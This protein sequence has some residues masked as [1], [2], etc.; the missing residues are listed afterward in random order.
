VA[1]ALLAGLLGGGVGAAGVALV[2]SD[3]SSSMQEP[4]PVDAAPLAADNTSVVAVADSLLPSV[5]QIKVSSET[6]Q[7][8]GSGFVLDDSGHVSPTTTSW[9]WRPTVA[10][11]RSCSTAARNAEPPSS[12]AR[13]RTTWR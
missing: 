3:E 2:D 13:R 11:S 5:V 1:T 4:L 8:T 7:G 6:E 10:R 12:D 9:R